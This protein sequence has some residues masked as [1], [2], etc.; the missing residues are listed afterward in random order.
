MTNKR[1]VLSGTAI[2]A[3]LATA[4]LLRD[5]FDIKLQ[6]GDFLNLLTNPFVYAL[7]LIVFFCLGVLISQ[8]FLKARSEEG[9]IEVFDL[10]DPDGL[11]KFYKELYASYKDAESEIYLTGAGFVSWS[12]AQEKKT[13]EIIEATRKCLERG[14]NFFR[15]QTSDN[16]AEEWA[17]KFADLMDKFPDNLRVFS[18][19][20]SVELAN[21]ALID[22]DGPNPIVQLLFETEGSGL[23]SASLDASVAVF[24]YGRRDLA[25]NLKARFLSRI[26]ESERL[27]PS[28]MRDLGVDTLYFTYGSNVSFDQMKK[29]CPSAQKLGLGILYGWE[30]AFGVEAPHLNGNTLGIYKNKNEHVWG[31]IYAISKKDKEELDKI[32]QGGYSPFE[33]SIKAENSQSHLNN[34]VTYVPSKPRSPVENSPDDRYLSVVLKGAKENQMQEFVEFLEAAKE[35]KQ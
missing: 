13:I 5:V 15:I 2:A 30:V 31:V 1:F 11:S 34:V 35:S 25:R 8:R 20:D 23:K 27:L 10:S 21:T 16:P 14:V 28:E 9:T 3:I 6:P 22:P 17:E 19:Y 29:R 12:D 33:V 7:G 18:D 32:E 26:H 4:T 24:I